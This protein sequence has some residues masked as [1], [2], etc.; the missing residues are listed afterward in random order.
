MKLQACLPHN[1]KTTTTCL[2]EEK[3]SF[4]CCCQSQECKY[5]Y[6]SSCSLVHWLSQTYLLILT[7]IINVLLISWFCILLPLLCV[8]VQLISESKATT[9]LFLGNKKYIDL[10]GLYFSC[11]NI[12][13]LSWKFWSSLKD[14][15]KIILQL[16]NNVNM[17]MP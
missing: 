10:E 15:V 7:C 5:R 3:M 2:T 17:L 16:I 4:Y 8:Y 12:N 1:L 9:H 14:L 13:I 6:W 11:R